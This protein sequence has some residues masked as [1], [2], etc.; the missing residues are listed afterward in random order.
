MV[1]HDAAAGS[2][3]KAAPASPGGFKV[4]SRVLGRHSRDRRMARVS[5]AEEPI[6]PSLRWAIRSDS[7]AP[8]G[9]AAALLSGKCH[10]CRMNSRAAVAVPVPSKAGSGWRTS[11]KFCVSLAA[12]WSLLGAS[13]CA[14]EFAYSL[15]PEQG[16][17]YVRSVP[18]ALDAAGTVLLVCMLPLCALIPVPLLIIGRRYLRRSLAGT[19]R[20]AAWTAVAS[21]SITV[22][23]LFWLRLY[24]N[25]SGPRWLSYPSWHALEFAAGF[26]IAGVAMAGVLL[27]IP[28]PAPRSAPP[29]T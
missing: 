8:R 15:V 1:A 6:P 10:D 7:P 17:Y 20:A 28:S 12:G 19:R 9:E 13:T 22:E 23:A 21:A 3:G 5:A 27:G 25:V 24:L 2:S 14:V 11:R 29:G 26:L 18:Y 4:L 16:P